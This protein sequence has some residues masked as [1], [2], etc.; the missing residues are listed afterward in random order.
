MSFNKFHNTE[1]SEF[2]Q[3]KNPL[4]A[5]HEMDHVVNELAVM[6]NNLHAVGLGCSEDLAYMVRHMR[7]LIENAESG[8]TRGINDR[9][10]AAQQSTSN[11]INA[12]LSVCS[13]S[14]K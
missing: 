12:A 13:V 5:V 7:S 14:D 11:M 9:Y 8:I 2:V 3:H 4:E 10:Q 6:A 1:D